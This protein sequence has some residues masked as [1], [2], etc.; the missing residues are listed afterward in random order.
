MRWLRPPKVIFLKGSIRWHS[1]GFSGVRV[2]FL[3][4]IFNKEKQEIH[5][6]DNNGISGNH[7]D[8]A[9]KGRSSE[10]PSSFNTKKGTFH[11]ANT[12]NALTMLL[13]GRFYSVGS[14]KCHS[15][16]RRLY[17]TLR[18]QEADFYSSAILLTNFFLFIMFLSF[19]L[20]LLSE[21]NIS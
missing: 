20:I 14:L 12:Q 4:D 1:K 8:F 7:Y 3:P 19:G 9:I 5:T 21:Q 15:E 6:G 13:M 18:L 2:S 11:E 16:K 10:F 17:N